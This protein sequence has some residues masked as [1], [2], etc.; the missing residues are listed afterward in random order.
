MHIYAHLCVG[1]CMYE[2][3][4]VLFRDGADLLEPELWLVVSCP[5]WVLGTKFRS[6]EKARITFNHQA[7]SLSPEIKIHCGRI[8]EL[9]HV[10][11]LFMVFLLNSKNI[12]YIL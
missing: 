6:S 10:C 5:I 12:K 7:I 11:L 1:M 2:Y 9:F 4:C 8:Y 3:R